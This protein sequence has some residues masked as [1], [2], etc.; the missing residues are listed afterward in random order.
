[1]LEDNDNTF[2]DKDDDSEFLSPKYSRKK[3]QDC[4]FRIAKESMGGSPNH[5]D[6][7]QVEID[8]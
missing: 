3:E 7:G 8:S 5:T 4:Y 6:D 2:D 1:M